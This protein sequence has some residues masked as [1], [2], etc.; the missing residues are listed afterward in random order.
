[1]TNPS[2]Y[3]ESLT[4]FSRLLRREG[5][6]VGL[7]ET[8]DALEALEVIGFEDR[9][10]V[11]TALRA[12][13]AKSPQEQASFDRL[14]AH[15]FVSAE[16][17][18]E[19]AKA[20]GAAEEELARRRASLEEDLSVGGK[21]IPLREDLKEVYLGMPEEEREKLRKK[22]ERY[23]DSAARHPGLYDNFI[24]SIFMR[25][26]LEQQMIAEDAGVGAADDPD[27]DLLYRDLS[28]FSDADIPKAVALIQRI[29]QQI[30]GEL[31]N[32]RRRGGHSGGAN[33]HSSVSSASGSAFW[34]APVSQK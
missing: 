5:L 13:F 26:L 3:L 30:S 16:R 20:M 8:M 10:T 12:I 4:E 31:T 32:K 11:R 34:N 21:Q 15:Y 18:R 28:S 1:M 14:F 6:T 9:E 27:A 19:N 23:Q 33:A 7:Q 29:A 24:Q 25:T 17:K 2:P 22:V